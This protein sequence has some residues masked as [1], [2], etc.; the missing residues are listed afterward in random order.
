MDKVK[1]GK[2]IGGII[3]VMF[4]ITLFIAFAMW[5]PKSGLTSKEFLIAGI[6]FMGSI[7]GGAITLIG[8][9]ITL[10]KKDE[11]D[12]LESFVSKMVTIRNIKTELDNFIDKDYTE[13][14]GLE[15]WE[16]ILQKAEIFSNIEK[17]IN[18]K[19]GGEVAYILLDHTYMISEEMTVKH[20]EWLRN[21]EEAIVTLYGSEELIRKQIESIGDS[22]KEIIDKL[23]D[24][25]FRLKSIYDGIKQHRLI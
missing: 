20:D 5:A 6:G 1:K 13:H 23:E 16:I 7:I 3:A 21:D 22:V 15:L 19:I 14:S 9:Q 10:R 24:E 11:E 4:I 12:F 17:D 25:E 18:N 8:V 2:T